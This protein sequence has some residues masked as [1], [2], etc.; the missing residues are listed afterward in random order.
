MKSCEKC[1]KFIS[2]GACV[3]LIGSLPIWSPQS[4]AQN[5]ESSPSEPV[6][7][8]VIPHTSSRIAMNTL[9]KAV[10]VLHVDGDSDTSR[11]FKLFS[12]DDGMI[13]FNVNPSEEA[14]EVAAFAVDCTSDGQSRTFGLELRSNS[15]PSLD[16]PAPTAEIRTPQASDVIRPALTKEEALQLSDNELVKREYPMRPDAQQAPGAFAAWL[17]AVIKPARR[18]DPR[19][20]ADPEARATGY[21]P[22]G[23]WSGFD[24]KNAPNEVPVSTYDLVQAEWTVPT[25]SLSNIEQNTTTYSSF[26]IGLDGD[27]GICPKYCSGDGRYSDLWQAG[28]QQDVTNFHYGLW[29]LFSDTF[30]TYNAWSEFIPGQSTQVLANFNVSPG[31]LMFSQV[32]VANAGGAPSLSGMF[33][34]AFVMNM[35]KNEYTWV[36]YC[37]GLTIGGNCTSQGQTPILGY[38]AEWIMERPYEN[39]AITDLADYNQAW[40]YYP[41]AEQTNG[42]WATYNGANSQ[43]IY[44]YNNNTNHLLSVPFVWNS[45]TIQYIWYNFH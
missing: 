34:T 37:R 22:A 36:Y 41:Y 39:G 17:Q 35:T 19:Q 26:W 12:D 29:G 5:A 16:M 6:R 42:A 8:T 28:T 9:P 10:C 1:M 25:V 4:F 11:S 31:D 7:L 40:M 13:R 24:V 3:A 23:G 30:S 20:V 38:Q 14:D 43:A 18:V 2:Y 15:S 32:Y 21:F 33:A 27:N 44:M 45:S